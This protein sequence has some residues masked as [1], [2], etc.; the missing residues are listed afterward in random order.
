VHHSADTATPKEAAPSEAALHHWSCFA[1]IELAF[2]LFKL[3]CDYWTSEA[4]HVLVL[5]LF[6]LLCKFNALQNRLPCKVHGWASNCGREVVAR[7]CVLDMR[8][9]KLLCK[10]N[11]YTGIATAHR[12]QSSYKVASNKVKKKNNHPLRW[13]RARVA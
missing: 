4:L 7:C 10:Y 11:A 2:R 12:G 3:L 1:G 13:N 9:C 6:N 8:P 5:R